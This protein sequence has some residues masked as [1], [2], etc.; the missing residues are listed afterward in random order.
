MADEDARRRRGIDGA[1]AA[2]RK[3]IVKSGGSDPGQ[4]AAAD[5]VRLAV[6]KSETKR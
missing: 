1:A 5:R 4:R 6:L 3:Q 2:L